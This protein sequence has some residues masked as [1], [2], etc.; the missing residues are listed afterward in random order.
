MG[1]SYREVDTTHSEASTVVAAMAV[2]DDDIPDGDELLARLLEGN[3]ENQEITDLV[4]RQAI[5]VGAFYNQLHA[6]GI[7]TDE[8]LELTMS[9]IATTCGGA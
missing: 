1:V 2:A 8:A 7:P 5:W 3:Q 4:R 6:E 9:Y